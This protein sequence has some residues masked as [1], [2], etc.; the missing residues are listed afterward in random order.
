MSVFICAMAV[1]HYVYGV[2][3]HDGNTGDLLTPADTL[4]MFVLI[5]G[6]GVFFFVMG[7]LLHRWD[8]A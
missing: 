6:T 4:L 3:V 7:I 5:G 2:P 1:A 8:P